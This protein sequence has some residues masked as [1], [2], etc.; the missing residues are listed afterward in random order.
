MVPV[1][2]YAGLT[3]TENINALSSE[4]RQYSEFREGGGGG[5][6]GRRQGLWSCD[7]F[8]YEGEGGNYIIIFFG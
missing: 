4:Y 2:S 7:V 6:K 5:S 3:S 1:V 8:F